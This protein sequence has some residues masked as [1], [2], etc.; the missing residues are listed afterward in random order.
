MYTET[1]GIVKI[2]AKKM[3]VPLYKKHAKLEGDERKNVI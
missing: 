1:E 2:K 3:R